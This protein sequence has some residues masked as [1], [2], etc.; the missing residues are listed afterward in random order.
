MVDALDR[1]DS[2]IGAMYRHPGFVSRFKSLKRV[3]R[4][5]NITRLI[6]EML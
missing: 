6:G 2:A 1:L 5:N 4:V 3:P